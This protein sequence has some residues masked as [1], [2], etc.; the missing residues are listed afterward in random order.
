MNKFLNLLVM[1]GILG[2]F[3]QNV[4]AGPLINQSLPESLKVDLEY[5]YR[6]EYR[7]NFDFNNSVSD[8]DTFHLGRG[9]INLSYNP[10]K[11]L[12]IF[13]QGQDSRLWDSRPRAKAGFENFMDVRQLYVNY[14]DGIVFEPLTLNKVSLR[15]GRQEFSY[16]AQR[17][18]GAFNWSNVAQTFDGAK[19]GFHFAKNHVQLD[20]FGGDKTNNKSPREADDLYDGSS[21]DRIW[22]YYATAKAFQETTIENYLI[23]RETYKNFSFGPSGSSEIDNYTF[24]GRLKKSFSNG[25]DYELEAAGQW[26]NF[27]SQDVRSAMAVGVVGYTFPKAWQPRV[28]FEFDY[29]SGD[30]DPNDGELNTF[31][32]LYPTN[33]LHYGYI[34]FIS[35]QNLND[36]RYQLSFKPHKKLRVQTDLHLIYLDTPKDSWYSAGRT[37]T[38]TAS[39]GSL[40]VNP[41]VGNEIDLLADYKLNNY[42]NISLGYS[43]F[44]AGGY[45]K[46]TGANDDA[47]FV[48]L[49]TTFSL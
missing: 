44:F 47:D 36:Y 14:E 37:V 1:L 41:H 49:Q 5:R 42:C 7:E 27:R 16:G 8:R 32:N 3:T 31:D 48:Y 29:G 33:H 22:A 17:L 26:G 34:D 9:R 45:L 13:I 43:R 4:F 28:A 25:F 21:K 38:R 24:G 39:A 19:A 40:E 23:H 35:L 18:I 2:N 11:E 12:G 20:F 15:A 30:S 10:I 46:E 6:L